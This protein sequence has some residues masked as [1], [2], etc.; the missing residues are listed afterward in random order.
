MKKLF[1]SIISIAISFTT[2]AQAPQSFQYQAV[3]RNVIPYPL[4]L[5]PHK[6]FSFLIPQTNFIKFK[7]N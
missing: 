4:G 2:F 6:P 1:F 7:I 5:C 3:V